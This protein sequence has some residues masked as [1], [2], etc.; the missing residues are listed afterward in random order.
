MND[1]TN[2][3]SFVKV[4]ELLSKYLQHLRNGNGTLSTFWMSYIDIVEVLF[5]MIRASRE[6]DW[7]LHLASIRTLIPWC[8]AYNRLNYPHYIPA[9]YAEM[10]NLEEHNQE[11]HNYLTDGGFSVQL[12]PD[13]SFGRIPV[14][15]TIEETVNK[16]TQTAGGTKGFSLKAGTI[17]RY[18][19]TAE[20]RSAFLRYLR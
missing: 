19:L 7:Q 1:T 12:G 4:A 20:Y 5:N 13:N 16:D 11:V 18:Y 3:T 10:K 6:A 14:D 17:N 8:F 2:E 15:Q 9:C